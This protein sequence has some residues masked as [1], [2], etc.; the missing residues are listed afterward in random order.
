MI[1]QSKCFEQ[2]KV[3]PKEDEN[4]LTEFE[5]FSASKVNHGIDMKIKNRIFPKKSI[6]Y[7]NY[8]KNFESKKKVIK[9]KM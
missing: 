1:N 7:S 9:F 5:I 3:K 6:F 4:R 2:V 8:S